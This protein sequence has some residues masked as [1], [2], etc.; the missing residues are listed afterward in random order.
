MLRAIF[1]WDK[2]WWEGPMWVIC[3]QTKGDM[4]VLV[5][6]LLSARG[7]RSVLVME[8]PGDVCLRRPGHFIHIAF[9]QTPSVQK[10]MCIA[11]SAWVV[12]IMCYIEIIP[13]RGWGPSLRLFRW[14]VNSLIFYAHSKR[15][16]YKLPANL[17][18]LKSMTIS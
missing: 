9:D 12:L 16:I 17:L 6:V 18:S 2:S 3:H 10:T 13:W 5:S 1:S 8:I 11:S 15:P 14:D 4:S 7:A